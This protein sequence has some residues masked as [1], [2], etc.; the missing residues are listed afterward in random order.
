M[1][2]HGILSGKKTYVT[3]ALAILTTVGA[4]LTGTMDMQ[5]SVAAIFA[6]VYAA[7]FRSAMK[8]DPKK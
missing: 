8:T 3:S 5:T 1:L 4:Y 2:G 6:A 7:T